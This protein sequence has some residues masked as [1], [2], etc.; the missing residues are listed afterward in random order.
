[1]INSGNV[2]Q[3]NQPYSSELRHLT[4]DMLHKD[5][6]QRISASDILNMTFIQNIISKTPP[7]I[8][9]NETP[10]EHFKLGK[11]ALSENRF[12]EA[13][14]FLILSIKGSYIQAVNESILYQRGK[15]QN[16]KEF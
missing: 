13:E 4:S 10:E 15:N 2:P 16:S 9:S 14:D 11:Q 5:P 6:F 12:D 7:Q 1:L 3:I 8:E